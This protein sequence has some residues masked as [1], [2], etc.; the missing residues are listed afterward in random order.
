[1]D[2]N[3][4]IY[5]EEKPWGNFRKFT[6]NTPSTIKIITVNP[7]EE[8]SLQSHAKRAEFWRVISGHGVF[9]IND[10]TYE[11]KIG[12][13]YYVPI[14]VKHRIKA[15]PSGLAVLEISLGNFDE[16]DIVRYED[17]YGRV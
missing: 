13:E 11:V 3:L 17:D 2:N 10:K 7:N 16:N 12:D 4:K 14:E 15:G 8:I 9:E 1:M 5:Q 6:D